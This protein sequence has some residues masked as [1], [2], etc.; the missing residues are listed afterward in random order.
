MLIGDK[1]SP[2]HWFYGGENNPADNDLEWVYDGLRGEYVY[3]DGSRLPGRDN[4]SIEEVALSSFWILVD[5]IYPHLSGK[6]QAGDGM[7]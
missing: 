5:D 4:Y 2:G 6:L 1:Y 3:K 7:W